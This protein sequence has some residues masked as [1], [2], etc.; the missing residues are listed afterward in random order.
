MSADADAIAAVRERIVE[1]GGGRVAPPI[2]VGTL[3]TATGH[4]VWVATTR[5]ESDRWAGRTLV[6]ACEAWL[7]AHPAP[8]GG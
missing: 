2:A 1:R 5:E 8:G 6:E 4:G 3:T 7:L